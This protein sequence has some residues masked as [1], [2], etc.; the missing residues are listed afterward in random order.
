[1]SVA[2]PILQ[3]N[4]KLEM[5]YSLPPPIHAADIDAAGDSIRNIESLDGDK[6][7]SITYNPFAIR[8]MQRYTP[9]H[10]MFFDITPDNYNHVSFGH[11]Y[12]VRNI[13]TVFDDVEK[14]EI[15]RPVFV[16][17]SPMLNPIKE[18]TEPLVNGNYGRDRTA[19]HLPCPEGMATTEPETNI[20]P[21]FT[22]MMNT[23]YTDN[24]CCFL[25][26]VML[27]EMNFINGIDYY[28][29]FTGIQEWFRMDV[30]DDI[31][32]LVSSPDFCAQLGN[33]IFLESTE[34]ELLSAVKRGVGS[35]TSRPAISILD[36][37]ASDSIVAESLDICE[38]S[39]D[40]E[41]LEITVEYETP[42][43]RG[44]TPDAT[45]SDDENSE[46]GFDTGSDDDSGTDD[47]K[48]DGSVET[49]YKD[50]DKDGDNDDGKEGTETDG[51]DDHD[52]DDDDYTDD[53][54][55]TAIY[56][57]N[58]PVQMI[59]LEK[60]DGTL[61]SLFE[62]EALN[63]EEATAAL[64]Q[65]IVSLAAYQKVLQLTHND[66]HT[67]NI[68]YVNTELK[69][70]Y[71]TI[72]ATHFRVPTYGRIFKI[73]DFGRS[74]FKFNGK[75]FCNDSFSKSGD[76]RGQY[77]CPPYFN[78]SKPRIDPNFS[79]DLAR[80]GC[81][82]L[83]LVLTREERKGDP[84]LLP[85][86][87]RMVLEWSQDDSGKSF[88][89]ARDDRERYP[90]FQLYKMIARNKHNAVPRKDVNRSIFQLYECTPKAVKAALRHTPNAVCDI[91]RMENSTKP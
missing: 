91:D 47:A 76:A 33:T 80:L 55:E 11:R 16:K 4:R 88:I 36:G 52:D 79:F 10:S 54:G 46:I 64:F 51:E 3:M 58:F 69:Y 17:F 83:D 71:Y 19:M 5:T 24:L 73:I 29:S 40:T 1:M 81:S 8:D 12:H 60:C 85:G 67:N 21:E 22:D 68:M 6:T 26:S 34:P 57:R 43:I 20:P 77:N 87:K 9:M 23:A 70:L 59:C 65:V 48:S 35:R 53:D 18:I 30:T 27:R 89:Y 82:L 74:I 72:N 32:H 56:I 75:V 50:G 7:I 15:A 28:G 84:S 14:K 39:P 37:D 90:G 78:E 44:D 2:T 61:D 13:E 31:E 86:Y 38:T 25:S 62:E 45:A 49:E 42:V 66:L 41:P 63:D